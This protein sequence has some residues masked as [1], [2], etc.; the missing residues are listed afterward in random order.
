MSL[1]LV[2]LLL[3]QFFWIANVHDLAKDQFDKDVTLALE[4][5]VLDLEKIEAANVM[6]PDAFKMGLQGS[7][8]HFVRNEFGH[9]MRPQEAIEVRDTTIMLGQERLKFLVVSGTTIDT[10][11]GLRAEHRVITKDLGE[12]MVSGVEN[13][14]LALQ[15]SNS[16]A[17]Q[18]NESYERQIMNKA[19]HLNDMIVNLFATNLFDDIRLRLNPVLL[20][21]IIVANLKAKSVDT[22]YRFNVVQKDEG[23]VQFKDRCQR[24]DTAM[25]VGEFQVMLYPH[26]IVPADYSV[27]VDFPGE[28]TYLWGEMT[29]T[30]F[31]SAALVIIIFY[32]FYL[33]VSTIYRQ[34]QLSEIRNDFISN[35]T[36]ELKTPISTI[37]L[38]CEAIADPDVH[39]NPD[40]MKQFVGMIDQENKRLGKLVE[41]VL[42][43][44]L[45][46]KGRLKL[47]LESTRIDKLLNDAVASFQI[48]YKDK[49]GEIILNRIDAFS[50]DVDKIHF[51]N[52]IFNLL[53]NALKYCQ[54]SPVVQLNLISNGKGFSL[55]VVDNGIGIRKEDQARIFEKLYR[56]PTGDVHNVKG[57]GLGLS[58]V[59]SIV[60]LHRGRIEV[61]STPGKGSTFKIHMSNE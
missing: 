41:N 50:W 22:V 56:V 25:S 5:S 42:Q 30:L 9:V 48:R 58:Y 21:S 53:D 38:A 23:P 1:A 43:T 8:D 59:S 20:D 4:K 32:A 27:V 18:L 33:S 37:S 54:K 46:E 29:G 35:M 51:G 24:L 39:K 16:F 10:A 55:E 40:T 57:F 19:R 14:V 36:H 31:S 44:S 7:Y 6:T 26:D 12:M 60:K 34:K 17:I 3:L 15:D 61:E 49:N 2:G 28:I 45:I 13:S 52:I 47:H 11:T